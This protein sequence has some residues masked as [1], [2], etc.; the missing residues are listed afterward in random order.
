MSRRKQA[1]PQH[2]ASEKAAAL[3]QVSTNEG[4]LK[5]SDQESGESS[6]RE[7]THASK[8]SCVDLPRWA[9]HLFERP[10]PAPTTG[11]P[12]ALIMQED[13]GPPEPLEDPQ[14][15]ASLSNRL[16]ND[17]MDT[18]AEETK[19]AEQTHKSS[20]E[21]V[22]STEEKVCS[23]QDV[24]L[25]AE[26]PQAYLEGAPAKCPYLA[27]L[28]STVG[29]LAQPHS[30]CPSPMTACY[31][32]IPST[33][34]TLEILQSTRVAVAQFSQGL[35][36]SNGPLRDGGGGERAAGGTAG[37][38][39]TILDNLLDLQ[40][41]QIQQLRLIEL[42]RHQ[43]ALLNKQA[44][45]A[46][47]VTQSMTPKGLVSHVSGPRHL[48]AV[49]NQPVFPLLGLL[50]PTAVNGQVPGMEGAVMSPLSLHP[51]K[52]QEQSG[53][54][55]MVSLPSS[56]RLPPSVQSMGASSALPPYNGSVTPVTGMQP[57]GSAGAPSLQAN[58]V[59]GSHHH[60]H[61]PSSLPLLPPSPPGGII[62]PNP[63]ASIMATTNALD[64]LG[65]LMK[66]RK[67][68]LSNVSVFDGSGSGSSSSGSS[69]PSSD[70]AFFKHRCRFCAKVFGSDSA[71]QI[72]LRSHTGE[73]PFKCN[74]CGNR[75]STKGNLKVHF[76]RHKDKYPNVQMNPYPVPEYLDNVPTSSGIP[77]GMSVLP[78]KASTTWLDSRP[79]ALHAQGSAGLRL[80]PNFN[81]NNSGG[82]S[83]DS[84]STASSAGSPTKASSA[85]SECTSQSPTSTELRKA[86]VDTA[87]TMSY[88]HLAE[89]ALSNLDHRSSE[90]FHSQNDLTATR[91]THIPNAS[92]TTASLEPS[93]TIQ[94]SSPMSSAQS[95]SS[96]QT[97]NSR[98]HPELD[99]MEASE[100]FKLQQ[101][102]E[103]I[104]K[105][106]T[107]DPNECVICH[108]VLS[109]QNAL[110]MH[111]RIHT[112][113]RPFKCK[114][115]GRAFSTKGNLKTHFGVHRARPPL[116][117]QH[118]CPIC[119][120]K[121]TN[122]VVLQQHIRMH[123]VGS[124]PNAPQTEGRP[125]DMDTEL[126]FDE[127]SLD[128]VNNY[129]EDDGQEDDSIEIDDEQSEDD[130]LNLQADSTLG[131]FGHESDTSD[132]A[133]LSF[134]P[135]V[136][137]SGPVVA[138]DF[139]AHHFLN[140]DNPERHRE[141]E[142]GAPDSSDSKPVSLSPIHD[143]DTNTSLQIASIANKSASPR[144]GADNGSD[145]RS[146]LE[147]GLTIV[148]EEIPDGMLYSSREQGIRGCISLL[149]NTTESKMD[150]HVPGTNS[151]PPTGRDTPNMKHIH[152]GLL[153]SPTQGFP[154][155][156]A[157]LEFAS[158]LPGPV[159]PV[160]TPKQHICQ[161]CAK[162]FSSASALQI[163]RRTH[164]G[165]KP[166][167]CS[168]CGRAFTT[169]GNLKVHM[170][171]HMWNSMPP[172]RG[173]RLSLDTSVAL[174]G[175]EALKLTEGFQ[176]DMAA[177]A[178]SVDPG[179]W[180]HYAAAIT[181]S[182]AMKGNEIS[183]IHNGGA[184]PTH[185]AQSHHP[186]HQGV[187][188]MGMERVNNSGHS[189]D[190]N[191]SPV[192]QHFPAMLMDTSKENCIN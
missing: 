177:R 150:L 136:A 81:L 158:H 11:D 176:K 110:K 36:H 20:V 147:N 34:V 77:Y 53:I 56:N 94:P 50:P 24:V 111:Y 116:W 18:P 185:H 183:V 104:D 33:N 155:S 66:H 61:Q 43:V 137:Q 22:A 97:H 17:G 157:K 175:S 138:H 23:T 85:P 83:T 69:K 102:V 161:T 186:H 160:R 35:H 5:G 107:T 7:P 32:G 73:R 132:K 159:Q 114:V 190:T 145:C 54:R 119:Q 174:L 26:P 88:G 191:D 113:E 42:I 192:G 108:R 44:P 105:N 156:L 103:N 79:L 10:P 89:S 134:Q 41:Q 59:Q 121:F 165:E 153:H 133:D 90:K 126:S 31:G 78:D 28:P 188:T 131:S 86:M 168:V 70:D 76:Q 87:S 19:P 91:T 12:P 8:T 64:P 65:A 182:M 80:P 72:H 16:S 38:L 166:F 163:H 21:P 1:N 62:F 55:S 189:S 164:T 149:N 129:D 144:H 29:H 37:Q 48:Q 181:N 112:G 123:M 93:P 120:K 162:T 146:K 171:T 82:K 52:A 47:E 148:K 127:N 130:K 45:P 170:G 13:V 96:D 2:L 71:L 98:L 178:M 180:N 51:M 101:L 109:C 92:T 27:V 115:C 106:P 142:A 3:M 124:L 84:L 140:F 58:N 9:H 14:I 25:K 173:R 179:F 128:S 63:L 75:F 95:F 15:S 169:K 6:D 184:P 60:H 125:Q 143:D 135:V 167:S 68:K 30:L 100:T 74:I 57:S 99:A 151:S 141:K 49:L 122:A 39:P 118:S 40:Q 172:R 117:V 154:P 139:L 4:L 187:V 67:G 152:S 46:A